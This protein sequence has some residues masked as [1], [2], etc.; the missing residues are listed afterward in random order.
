MDKQSVVMKRGQGETL[1][2]LGTSVRFL[3][4]SEK[5]ANG[6]SVMEVVLPK[7]Q[8]PPPHEHP[9]DEAYYILEG[10][11]RF[12][13]GDMEAVFGAGDF[14]YAPGGVVHAFRGASEAPARVLVMDAPAAAEKFFRE[15]DREV[16]AMPQDLAK[17]PEIGSKHQLTFRTAA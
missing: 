17:L 5:T 16:K 1:S 3:C 11:A 6:F 9:W 13:V 4:E 8:G 12:Q 2:V 14:L 10:Q 7:D 15:V